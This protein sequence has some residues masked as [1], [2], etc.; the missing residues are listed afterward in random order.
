MA[1][2]RVLAAAGSRVPEADCFVSAGGR[3][4]PATAREG[5]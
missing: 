3:K 5:H 1:L 2:K 4:K